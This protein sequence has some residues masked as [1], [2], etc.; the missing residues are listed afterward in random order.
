MFRSGRHRCLA[1]YIAAWPMTSP[2]ADYIA[3]GLMIAK[4]VAASTESS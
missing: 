1:D 2:L 3:A 4:V